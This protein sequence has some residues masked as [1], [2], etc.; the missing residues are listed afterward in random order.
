MPITLTWGSCHLLKWRSRREGDRASYCVGFRGGAVSNEDVRFSGQLVDAEDCLSHPHRIQLNTH[1]KHQFWNQD[2]KALNRAVCT[3]PRVHMAVMPA[4]SVQHRAPLRTLESKLGLRRDPAGS[5]V[6]R[7][8]LE[9]K[10]MQ[11]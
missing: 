2:Q 10:P 5:D 3:K 7:G 11:A 1:Y 6:A 9:R 8:M 4:V